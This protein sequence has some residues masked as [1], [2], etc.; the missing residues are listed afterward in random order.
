MKL[1]SAKVTAPGRKQVFRRPGRTDIL[2]LEDEEPPAGGRPLIETVMG[3]GKRLGDRPG[4]PAGLAR[5]RER[6]AADLA[7]LP[8]TA[9][10]IRN[11]TAPRVTTSPRLTA[12]TDQV[13]CRIKDQL[14]HP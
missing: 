1:S 14:T 11:P 2:G 5:A 3:D 12:L 6:F 9:R 13:R 7:E 4:G 10:L 8:P